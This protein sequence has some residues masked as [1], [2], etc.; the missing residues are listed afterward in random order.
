MKK[1]I[2]FGVAVIAI[3]GALAFITSNQNQ[4]QSEGNPFGKDRLHQETID[5]LDN[6]IY[7]NVILPEELDEKIEGEEDFTV[8]FY[9][10]ACHV[11][12]EVSPVLVPLAEDKGIDLHL[13]NLLEFQDGFNHYDIEGTPTVVHYENGEEVDRIYGGAEEPTYELFYDQVVLNEE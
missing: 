3:F 6:P 9:S 2:L 8:Y 13:F 5:Q 4:Q 7:S 11:C 1:L 12:Q 10:P